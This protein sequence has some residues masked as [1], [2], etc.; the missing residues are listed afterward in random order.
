MSNILVAMGSGKDV[1]KMVR[2]QEDAYMEV[3]K[4]W[5]WKCMCSSGSCSWEVKTIGSLLSPHHS[6]LPLSLANCDS[7]HCIGRF[8]L[9]HKF[10]LV[11]AQSQFSHAGFKELSE[12]VVLHQLNEDA[13]SLLFWH[14]SKAASNQTSGKSFFAAHMKLLRGHV[15]VWW[16]YIY[17][18]CMSS[19]PTMNA[20]PWQ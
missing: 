11:H 3:W 16:G 14:L 4:L 10:K 17:Y 20:L 19:N 9:D 6:A 12:S 7:W 15:F 8:Y 18:T 2:N 13:E 1:R 5:A